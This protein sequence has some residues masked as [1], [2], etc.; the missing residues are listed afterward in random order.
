MKKLKI[1][2]LI[3]GMLILVSLMSYLYLN[4]AVVKEYVSNSPEISATDTEVDEDEMQNESKIFLPD[5]ELIKKILDISKTL[6]PA[7]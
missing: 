4:S 5:I 6:L 1:Q 7:E 3:W 2:T